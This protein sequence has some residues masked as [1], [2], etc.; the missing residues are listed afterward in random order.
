MFTAFEWYFLAS[1]G[2]PV[3]SYLHALRQKS[4]YDGQIVAHKAGDLKGIK[5]Y[6]SSSQMQMPIYVGNQNVQIPV[7]GG[8]FSSSWDFVTS[9]F[10]FEKTVDDSGVLIDAEIV[11]EDKYQTGRSYANRYEELLPVIESMNLTS[12]IPITFPMKLVHYTVPG[13]EIYIH[14]PTL[15]VGKERRAVLNGVLFNKRLPGTLTIPGLAI[16][17]VG[18]AWTLHT[19]TGGDSY[20]HAPPTDIW[21][22]ITGNTA[23][24]RWVAAHPG[25]H[26]W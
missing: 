9:A 17:I 8:G 18:T 26:Y 4:S 15:I 11:E 10:R 5:F 12:R 24:K 23:E 25:K 21:G 22:K 3:I 2:Y 6:K 1:M 16:L 19:L 13:P 7:G 14:K 20:Y